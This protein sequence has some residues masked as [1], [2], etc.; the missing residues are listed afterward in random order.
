MTPD[1]ATL[2]AR[3][4][5]VLPR[6]DA[7][8]AAELAH[9]LR[10]LVDVFRPERIYAFGSQARGDAGPDSDVDLLLVV[11]HSELPPHQRDQHAYHAIGGHRL[12]VDILVWTRAEFDGRVQ[13]PSSLPATV[14]REGRTLYES[15]IAA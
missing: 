11:S 7:A 3:I 8:G 12:P 10:R 1:T 5:D 2:E 4:R 15:T 6:L 14:L 13:A 9:M